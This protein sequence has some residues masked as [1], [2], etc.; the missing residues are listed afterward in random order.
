MI[1]LLECVVQGVCHFPIFCYFLYSSIHLGRCIWGWRTRKERKEGDADG[2]WE[3][4][5]TRSARVID[6]VTSMPVEEEEEG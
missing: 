4:P 6:D 1:P 2:R 5:M 3:L